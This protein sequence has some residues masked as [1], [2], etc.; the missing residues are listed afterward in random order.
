MAVNH[1]TPIEGVS[2]VRA[3]N[4]YEYHIQAN[5]ID[6]TDGLRNSLIIQINKFE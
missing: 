1:C 3:L 5:P 2:R 6:L 4:F